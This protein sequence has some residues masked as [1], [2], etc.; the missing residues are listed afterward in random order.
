MKIIF[1]E[2][3][4]VIIFSALFLMSAS[5]LF[6]QN[7]REL[8]PNQGK[9]WWTLSFADP[10]DP[11]NLDF[12]VENHS[13]TTE[14]TYQILSE[15]QV[16][17]TGNISTKPGTDITIRREVTAPSSARVSIIVSDGIEKKEIYR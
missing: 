13:N 8:D 10:K 16:L 9:D 11:N 15:K 2:K 17:L 7:E 4:L 3:H 6:W 1:S 12:T 5:F 14:F